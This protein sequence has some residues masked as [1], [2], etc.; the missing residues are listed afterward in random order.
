M[1][2]MGAPRLLGCAEVRCA[3]EGVVVLFSQGLGREEES[4][5]RGGWTIR[6]RRVSDALAPDLIRTHSEF[7]L[8]IVINLHPTVI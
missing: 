3:H 1:E 7:I 8:L 5:E 6:H 2:W 4:K